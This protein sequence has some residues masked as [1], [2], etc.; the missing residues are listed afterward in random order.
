[1]KGLFFSTA[2]VCFVS[3]VIAWHNC[4]QGREPYGP[5]AAKLCKL[6]CM[7]DQCRLC[8]EAEFGGEE[9]WL[10]TSQLGVQIGT[11][12][13]VRLKTGSPTMF[14][15]MRP[16]FPGARRRSSAEL[17]SMHRRL[18]TMCPT[19]TFISRWQV[20]FPFFPQLAS[21]RTIWRTLFQ[22]LKRRGWEVQFPY[23]TASVGF[24]RESIVEGGGLQKNTK[25]FMPDKFD[26]LDISPKEKQTSC[27]R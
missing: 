15:I 23:R 2:E 25:C 16:L 6:C 20:L 11:C 5:E 26:V 9:F 1:M 18:A 8:S 14:P 24:A 17:S 27:Q 3:R 22:N 7:F 19:G 10:L 21:K 12:Y 4:V 13:A